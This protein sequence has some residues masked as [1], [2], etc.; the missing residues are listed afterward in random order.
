MSV[1]AP[2][3]TAPRRPFLRF[4]LP[5]L[6][7]ALGVLGVVLLR[8]VPPD[9]WENF[10]RNVSTVFVV[11]GTVLLLLL[12]WAFLAPVPGKVR[13]GSLLVLALLAGAA[14]ASFELDGFWGDIW[15]PRFRPRPWLRALL[16]DKDDA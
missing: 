15:P 9:D 12:W 8:T 1:P 11:L 2:D 3:T 7:V 16:G 4:W 13:W 14:S 6:I 5:W 10:Y